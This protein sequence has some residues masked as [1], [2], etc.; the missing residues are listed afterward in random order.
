MKPISILLA[1]AALTAGPAVRAQDAATEERLNKLAGQIE[2]LRA[3]QDALG[4][5]L[6]ALTKDIDGLRSALDKPA[7][8]YAGQ[9]DLKRLAEAV[10]E[11]DRKRLEDYDKIRSE[12]LKLG[13][14]L[15]APA[16]PTKKSSAAS[17]PDNNALTEKA[18]SSDKGFE[19]VVKKGDTLNLIANA[20][21]DNNIKVTTDQILKANPGL[22]PEKMHPGQKIFIPA[23][24][25]S[26]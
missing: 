24:Q 11:V 3:G 22:K 8:N 10:K 2:D 17:A 6:E 9:D 12:L 1:A 16:Q 18:S 13:K 7:G 5:R 20:Y 19:N 15:S 21:R 4:K 26:Q 14:T 25:T 23:P